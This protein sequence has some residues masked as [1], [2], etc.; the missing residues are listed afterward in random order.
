MPFLILIKVGSEFSN[1]GTGVIVDHTIA[2]ELKDFI[3]SITD[4]CCGTSQVVVLLR[5][6][7]L[8]PQRHRNTVLIIKLYFC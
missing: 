1:S 5:F 8:L 7:G 3:V 6:C 4:A 2:S